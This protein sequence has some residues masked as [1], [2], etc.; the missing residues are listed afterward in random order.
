MFTGLIKAI[1]TVKS[2]YTAGGGMHLTVD[3]G[4]LAEESK[5]GDSIAING[6]CLTVAQLRGSLADF[7]VSGET[8]TK[9]ALGKLKSSSP[10]NTE[11]AMKA[12]DRFGGHFVLGHVDGIATIK[13]IE[14]QGQFADIK[15]TANPK[16]LAQM[17]VKGS[18]AVDGISLTIANMDGDSFSVSIIPE[19]L[20]K[21]TLG[22]A[23]IGDTVNIETDIIIKTIKKQLEKILPTE[24]K[25]TAER[26]KELGF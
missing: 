18:V 1:C 12:T 14:R 4:K 8:L 10:V 6:V 19:T 5:I 22:Q 25:L 15:F 13:A 24:Q 20:K 26:L 2:A 17:V 3:L 11:L 23:K 7:D 16:L 9:S 21:T